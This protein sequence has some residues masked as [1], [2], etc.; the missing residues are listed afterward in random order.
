MSSP[1]QKAPPN[2]LENVSVDQFLLQLSISDQLDEQAPQDVKQC[3]QCNQR[4]FQI[5]AK[6]I[7][8]KKEKSF[9]SS[10]CYRRFSKIT[11]Y[12]EQKDIPKPKT[13]PRPNIGSYQASQPIDIPGF[14]R[15]KQPSKSHK[16]CID[17]ARAASAPK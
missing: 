7:A 9:C 12:V 2:S 14:A 8:N 16:N 3:F 17:Q 11:P 4:C 10:E 6:I 1:T 13:P 15:K 5:F